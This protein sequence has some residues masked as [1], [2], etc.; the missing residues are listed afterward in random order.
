MCT[1]HF[2]WL[3]HW[4][5][6]LKKYFQY[7]KVRK[8]LSERCTAACDI[9]LLVFNVYPSESRLLAGRYSLCQAV[10][11][12]W[13][14]TCQRRRYDRW[15]NAVVQTRP[16]TESLSQT[17]DMWTFRTNRCRVKACCT[18]PSPVAKAISSSPRA[19]MC[20]VSVTEHFPYLSVCTHT[21][22]TMD[23]TAGFHTGT[24]TYTD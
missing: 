11:P 14:E 15:L 6:K 13:T 20:S 23:H 22:W 3:T 8:Y 10:G 4:R 1:S 9:R 21:H 7:S 16:R 24:H 5:Y 12:R 17:E 19:N 18:L 2:L